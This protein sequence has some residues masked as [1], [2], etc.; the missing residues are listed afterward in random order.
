[1]TIT[2]RTLNASLAAAAALP[3]GFSLA[4]AKPRLGMIFPVIDR[5]VP[6]EAVRMYG[7]RVDYVIENLDLQTMTPEGY[8]AVID[9]IPALAQRLVERNVDAIMV[10]GTNITLH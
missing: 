10:M 7:E 3:S 6:D 5:G 8:D 9:D 4:Q 2:R 1:M